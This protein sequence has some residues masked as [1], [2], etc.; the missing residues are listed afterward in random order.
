MPRPECMDDY[1]DYVNMLSERYH[2]NSTYGP[3]RYYVVW[4]EIISAGWM[5]FSP[6]L[7]NRIVKN[8]TTGDQQLTAAQYKLWADVYADMMVRTS[9]AALRNNP[10]AIVWFSSDH[11]WLSPKQQAGDVLHISLN[12]MLDAIWERINTSIPWG[13]VV[14]PYDDGDPRHDLWDQGIYTFKTLNNIFEHQVSL[15]GGR[16]R[17]CRRSSRAQ[18][19]KRNREMAKSQLTRFFFFTWV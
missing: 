17:M 1:E 15:E 10:E 4:N 13:L 19:K 7:P 5:D 9:R 3:L 12:T 2:A 18:K 8:G 14:H 11:F 16:V 6:R